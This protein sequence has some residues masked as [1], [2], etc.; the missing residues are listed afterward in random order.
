MGY[1][2]NVVNEA[3]KVVTCKN[4]IIVPISFS[5]SNVLHYYHVA[6][7]QRATHFFS[8][9]D[10]ILVYS[11][12]STWHGMRQTTHGILGKSTEF[13]RGISSLMSI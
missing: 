3:Y 7:A 11:D 4:C 6:E 9:V 5:K 13:L 10:V 2:L 12:R 1:P 8:C